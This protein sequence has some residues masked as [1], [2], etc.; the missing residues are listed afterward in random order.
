M[1]QE[2]DWLGA[3]VRC[4]SGE[5]ST[6]AAPPRL[7]ASGRGYVAGQ[8]PQLPEGE[9]KERLRVL[10]ELDILDSAAEASFDHIADHGRRTF[11]VPICL[12]TLVDAN[13]QWFKACYGLDVNQTGRDAAFCA[14]AIMPGAPEIFEVT[15][16][17]ADE[18][19]ANNP[20]VTG[21]PFIR[22]YAGAP[23]I[24]E[25]RKLG[26]LCVIDVVPRAP[27]T[28]LE[29]E[30]LITLASMVCDQLNSRLQSQ[31]LTV[32]YQE[33]QERTAEVGVVNAELQTLID[34]ANAPIFAID[35]KLEVTVWNRKISEL[36]SIAQDTVKG[37]TISSLLNPLFAGEHSSSKSG[38]TAAG[39]APGAEMGAGDG[40]A[41]CSG[42]GSSSVAIAVTEVLEQALKGERCTC[43]DLELRSRVHG[44]PIQLQVSV[45]P[46]RDSDGRIV[47]AVCVGE[48]VA[49]RRRMLEATVENYNLQKTNEAKDAFLAIMSHEMRTPLNGL[50]GMLQLAALTEEHVPDKV[51]RYMKQAK[52][53]GMM[54]LHLINDI[55]DMTRIESGQMQLEP[56]SFSLHAALEETIEMVRPKALEK[57]LDLQLVV[58]DGLEPLRLVGDTMRIE[59]VLLNLLWNALKFT[60]SGFV[61]LSG[62][63]AARDASGVQ[64][65]LEVSDSGVGIAAEDQPLI[66]E[67]FAV[68][69]MNGR[70]RH[71]IGKSNG[72]DGGSV[73]LGMSICKQLVDLMGGHIWLHS[74]VGR[75]TRVLVQITLP[76]GSD[77]PSEMEGTAGSPPTENA[78]APSQAALSSGPSPGLHPI[79][80]V[81]RIATP[82]RL[83]TEVL[84]VEDNDYNVDV[85]KQMLEFL[86]HSVTVA[87]NGKEALDAIVERDRAG[88]MTERGLPFDIVL[89]DCDMPV[90]NGFEATRAIRRWERTGVPHP[91]DSSE[92][93]TDPPGEPPPRRQPLPIIAVTAY[94]MLGDKQACFDA[95]MDDYITKPLML[96]VLRDKMVVQLASHLS[97][98]EEGLEPPSAA[99]LPLPASAPAAQ[100]SSEQIGS[101]TNPLVRELLS[102]RQSIESPNALR[103]EASGGSSA[104]NRPPPAQLP[105][106][107]RERRDAGKQGGKK[108][109][110]AK[111]HAPPPA[112]ASPGSGA[113]LPIDTVD[114][115]KVLSLD[116]FWE[117]LPGVPG[118]ETSPLPTRLHEDPAPSACKLDLNE[119]LQIFGGNSELVRMA[120]KRFDVKSFS[121]LRE[122]W[123]SKDFK[124][125]GQI[126]HQ[127]KGTCS[128][129]SAK[130]AQRAA[131]RLEQSAKALG[132]SGSSAVLCKEVAAALYDLRV[133]LQ[134]IAPSVVSTLDELSVSPEAHRAATKAASRP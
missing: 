95:G 79:T 100:G 48:D 89:M 52:N 101:S 55:L 85:G 70:A 2:S 118:R 122:P 128:Y 81:P 93:A 9:E 64:L 77:E 84:I 31:K 21:A 51:N 121:R 33:L 44:R 108:G 36:T 40:G 8:F 113:G 37:R 16:A 103:R 133:E 45:E 62:R 23:L 20:L 92:G 126:A 131:L 19:F 82:L 54:L 132:D 123:E 30:T 73:G 88:K 115:D 10:R 109:A 65:L 90:M 80:S 91:P 17:A 120:L 24:M 111:S 97:K 14:H 56:R 99:L 53:S 13:R 112:P 102:G 25:G 87:F 72:S 1:R 104:I 59:Q 39:A 96:P 78:S 74:E 11:K 35:E 58:D 15:D 12:V 28:P 18:R 46:K 69:R 6:V 50:L 66:F 76:E 32:M 98:T 71:G 34:T 117:L 41:V 61:R 38:E 114:L 105:A 57:S 94:A 3:I 27:L 49:V 60:A 110:A 75:G 29:R 129:I 42:A 5:G 119:L 67:R 106:N 107:V 130:Q 22:Y 63:I 125:V 4:L 83:P 86:G 116:R 47:G 7:A 26:T 127:W 68:A 43:F 124:R 134:Q